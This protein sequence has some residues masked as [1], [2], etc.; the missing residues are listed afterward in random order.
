MP[1]KNLA[2]AAVA[3]V[4]VVTCALAWQA[5]W[6]P[7]LAWHRA[8]PNLLLVSIDTLRADR[9]GCY[10][11]AAAQTPVL[12]ALA[13]R[14]VRFAAA[15]TVTPLTLPAHASL[16]TGT[17]PAYHGVRDNGGF[18]LGDDQQTLAETLKAHGYRTGG[19]V[20]AFVLDRRWG[21]GQGFD[22]YFDDFDLSRYDMSVGLD[23]A[24]RPGHEVVDR[25]LA[26]LGTGAGPFFAWVHLYE[27]H[28]PY[29][30]PEPYRSRFPSTMEG[31][32]DGEIATAD[33]EV[34]RLLAYLDA[35]GALANTVVIVV[36]DHGESLGEH[37]EQQHGFFV[38]DASTRIPLIVAGP[39][40]QSRVVRSQVR[41]VDVMPTALELLGVQTPAAVQGASLV[42]LAR[43]EPRTLPALVETWYPRYHYGWSELS[44]LRDGRYKFIAAPRPE[45]YDTDADPGETHDLSSA[46]P[47]LAKAMA[48]ALRELEAKY[49]GTSGPQ[50]P[51]PVDAAVEQ[52]LRALGYVSSSV[53][54]T[55]LETRPRGD[56][57]D[58]IEL[59]NLLKLAGQDSVSGRIADGLAKVRQVLAADP[60]VI[61]AY[62]MLGNMHTKAGRR[63][64]AI[65][66]Y[67]QALAVD[68]EHEGAAW[69]LALAYKN[70]G[71][72]A[73]AQSGFERV[74]QLDARSTKAMWQL[75]DIWMRQGE[76][77]RAQRVL[78]QALAQDVDRAPFLVKLGESH[79]EQRQYDQ[80]RDRL[81]DAVKVKPTQPMAHY[82]L[83]LVHEA[84]SEW[85]EAASAY[86]RE[87]EISPKLYQ[88][89]FNLAKLL[90][91]AGRHGEAAAHFRQAI[92]LDPSFAEGHLY[93][94]KT[95][96]DTGDLSGAEA[97]ARQGLAA[98]P[99]ASAVALG[100]YVLADVYSR[101]GRPRDAAREAAT[102]L[103]LE[104][105]ARTSGGSPR[106]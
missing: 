49:A 63:E 99:K 94:A 91:R 18:Y 44:A 65:D 20:A 3:L 85:D 45:L 15:T 46:N 32:Y 103:R 64:E 10:G 106:S 79:I 22:T 76:F 14:G 66:A 88:P 39:G 30:P 2:A 73:D 21:V 83:G 52:Q 81:L 55:V 105:R 69:S 50:T 17:F 54:R 4:A 16:L 6:I 96:L 43:G 98:G 68:A 77:A 47:R 57:K 90:A 42:P 51:R 34:G 23:A 58:K 67:R 84:R 74:L 102:G 75:A 62:T 27:P 8:A 89:H 92:V 29:T 19:F 33:A 28:S 60:E 41:I 7:R 36:G 53:S 95:L 100:H 104:Q 59:Y 71:R 9:L 38:Y 26:W 25:A 31:A 5:G 70:A 35:H 87:I 56:P 82:D 78:Q 61:E 48:N 93:L 24:Q 13:G 86:R 97:E 72:L 12:D 1:R 101:L 40:L 80:A 37:R 11:Y